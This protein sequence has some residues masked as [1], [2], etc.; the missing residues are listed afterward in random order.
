MS[1]ARQ[2]TYKVAENVQTQ[3]A[4]QILMA[5]YDNYA[6][7]MHNA[8]VDTG[9]GLGETFDNYYDTEARNIIRDLGVS[10]PTPPTGTNFN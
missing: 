6:S 5:E 2:V 1:Q 4:N 8:P 7:M 3:S 9:D 10:I